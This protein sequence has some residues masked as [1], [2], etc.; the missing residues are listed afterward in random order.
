MNSEYTD[1][2]LLILLRLG[3]PCSPLKYD[4][5][6]YHIMRL[7]T[8]AGLRGATPSEIQ[9]NVIGFES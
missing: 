5:Q 9:G 2:D 1:I 4:R 6:D 3:I 8:A 7:R